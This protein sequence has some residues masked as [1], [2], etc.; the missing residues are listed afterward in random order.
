[1]AEF[2]ISPEEQREYLVRYLNR[3][4]VMHRE[5]PFRRC[6]VFGCTD[7]DCSRCVALTGHPCWWVREDLCGACEE[8]G[9]L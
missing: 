8:G 9:G 2:I 6:R 1:M 3:P 7:E 4:D 5:D